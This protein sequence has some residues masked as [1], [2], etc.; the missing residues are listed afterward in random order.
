MVRMTKCFALV[1][2]ICPILAATAR[3]DDEKKTDQKAVVA[4]FTFDGPVLE[5]PRGEELP[6]FSLAVRPSMKD[7]LERMKKAKDDK[8]VK[9][10]VLLLDE[11]HLGLAQIEELRQALDGIKASGKEVYAH[12]NALMV[13]PT[14][15]LAAGATRISATPTAII[16]ISGFNAEMPYVRG[17]LDMMGVKPDFLTC[18]AY[19]SAAEM[20]MRKVRAPNRR[21]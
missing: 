21:R 11:V 14:L 7:L 20:F 8:N 3:A 6:L 10:V 9:A 5:K 2:A 19:K 16:I 1:L 18:G 13:M 12:V 15:A 17:L 4:V